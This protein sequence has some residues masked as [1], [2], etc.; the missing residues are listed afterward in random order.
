MLVLD[1]AYSPSATDFGPLVGRIIAAKADALLGGGH[2]SDGM[3]LARTLHDRKA[4]LKW[5]ALLVAPACR[6]SPTWV[7]P[8]WV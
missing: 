4:G 3:A 5:V 2:A 6:N 1:E 7:T 8:R